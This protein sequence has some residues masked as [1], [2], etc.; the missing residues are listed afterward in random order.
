MNTI[1]AFVVFPLAMLASSSTSARTDYA[2]CSGGGRA[3]LFYSSVFPVVH[4]PSDAARAKAFNAF[5]KAK[6]GVTI[7]AEC[8]SDL[9]PAL[10]N[11]HKK[12]MEDSDQHSKFP[13]KL[14]ET[15]WVGK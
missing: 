9:T 3:S 8:H 5:I 13:S 10:A 11:S 15:G 4:G 7:F 12:I 2:F 14:I 1:A 6:Y